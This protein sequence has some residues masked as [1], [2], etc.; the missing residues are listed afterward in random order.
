MDRSQL[1][2][3]ITG[4]RV[5]RLAT[6]DAAGRP[7]VVPFVF[8]VDGDHIY[9][10]VDHKPKR[11]RQ[12]KRMRNIEANPQVAVL[13]D[14]YEDEWSRLWWARVD[15]T[16]RVVETGPA[17]EQAIAALADKYP[18]YRGYPPDGSAMV[19]TIERVTG[20]TADA[21]TIRR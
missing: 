16:A 4:A 20:W 21:A 5:A 7:H 17:W 8:A 3:R 18:Q 15:G 19:I 12:L 6:V 2:K 14:H 11:T 1:L 9:S 10:A 13:V